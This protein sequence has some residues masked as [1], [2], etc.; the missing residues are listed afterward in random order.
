MTV[1]EVAG[2]LK[3][4]ADRVFPNTM[5]VFDKTYKEVNFLLKAWRITS[6]FFSLV[7]IAYLIYALAAG[8]GHPYANIA[9]L[10]ISALL[11]AFDLVSGA[12]HGAD[13]KKKRKLFRCAKIAIGCLKV[14]MAVYTVVVTWNDPSVITVTLAV[15][16]TVI[17][18]AQVVFEILYTV[19]HARLE[20]FRVAFDADKAAISKV[21]QFGKDAVELAADIIA[22]RVALAA[23][24]VGFVGKLLKKR[25][26][27]KQEAA[28]ISDGGDE[29][30]KLLK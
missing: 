19:C 18:L 26:K 29:E 2:K 6:I 16:S 9:F 14:A 4:I 24:G 28:S 22:P 12:A 13:K 20:L 23:K 30:N 27:D 7:Y 1:I 25:K 3:P 8:I 5:K 17:F 11:F 21:A 10:V 15:I